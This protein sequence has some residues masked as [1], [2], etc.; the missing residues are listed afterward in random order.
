MESVAAYIINLM[1]HERTIKWKLRTVACHA[2]SVPSAFPVRWPSERFVSTSSAMPDDAM[3]YNRSSRHNAIIRRSLSTCTRDGSHVSKHGDKVQ[4]LV[5]RCG[6]SDACTR[7]TAN[8][9]E[10]GNKT[11]RRPSLAHFFLP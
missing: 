3:N 2:C 7:R 4:S 5:L 1:Q 9:K 11:W 6:F 10:Q 8:H